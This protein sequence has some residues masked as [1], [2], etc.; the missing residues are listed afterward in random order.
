MTRQP[1]RTPGGVLHERVQKS[2][3]ADLEAALDPIE[4][5]AR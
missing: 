3:H 1:G 2:T 5:T 4:V